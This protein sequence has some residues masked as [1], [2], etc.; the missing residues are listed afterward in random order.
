MPNLKKKR[1]VKFSY[2]DIIFEDFT[3]QMS[4]GNIFKNDN[5]HTIFSCQDI[6]NIYFDSNY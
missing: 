4:P 1:Q 2:P 3:F 6:E 5:F